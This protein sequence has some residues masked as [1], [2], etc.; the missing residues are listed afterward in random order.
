MTEQYLILVARINHLEC[1]KKNMDTYF[2]A[3]SYIY[4]ILY[5]YFYSRWLK[6]HNQKN[7]SKAIENIANY[8]VRASNSKNTYI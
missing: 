5:T 1:Y 3:E 8:D 2:I 6:D 7:S 4:N